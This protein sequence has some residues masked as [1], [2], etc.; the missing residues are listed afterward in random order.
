MI[1]V[2]PA[3]ALIGRT[4][5]SEDYELLYQAS[6]AARAERQAARRRTA[7]RGLDRR[8]RG[9]G[10]PVMLPLRLPG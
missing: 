10:E 7:E 6:L 8:W 1:A 4:H 2:A 5:S 3:F 9:S